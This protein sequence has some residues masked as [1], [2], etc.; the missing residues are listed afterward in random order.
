MPSA[1]S[2]ALCLAVSLADRDA[3][4]RLGFD[5]DRPPGAV[6]LRVQ[7]LGGRRQEV[8]GVVR[9]ARVPAPGAEEEVVRR[10]GIVEALTLRIVALAY[11][12][13]ATVIKQR[14]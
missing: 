8:V 4:P 12:Y 7:S 10:R 1:R 11:R 2:A 5:V 9:P 14:A 3:R 13:R 6:A